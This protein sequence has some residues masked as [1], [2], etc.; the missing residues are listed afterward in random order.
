M[1]WLNK[2]GIMMAEHVTEQKKYCCRCGS[3]A[4]KTPNGGCSLRCVCAW[5]SAHG[6]WV[7]KRG[8]LTDEDKMYVQ[9]TFLEAHEAEPD[10]ELLL[11]DYALFL[12]RELNEW[13]QAEQMLEKALALPATSA[14]VRMRILNLYSHFLST[15]PISDSKLDA[16]RNGS[17]M[18]SSS[19]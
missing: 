19:A 18:N 8:A 9:R 12:W 4:D 5:Q 2:V 13:Q 10:N 17:Y 15:T 14:R 1:E 6:V 7:D 11:A 16:H 3:E